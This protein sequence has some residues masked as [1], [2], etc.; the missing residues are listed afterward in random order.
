MLRKKW[1]AWM[2]AVFVLAALICI[3]AFAGNREEKL[4]G[5]TLVK[6]GESISAGMLAE[7]GRCL[8]YE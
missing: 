7:K 1:W 6:N 2:A 5:G 4:S 3:F 8:S